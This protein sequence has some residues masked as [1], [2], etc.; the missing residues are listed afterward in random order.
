MTIIDND[1]LEEITRIINRDAQPTATES[2]VLAFI[3]GT[4]HGF[5]ANWLRD[6]SAEEIASWIIEQIWEGEE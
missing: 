4:P 2:D 3:A 5:G 6:A 1:K